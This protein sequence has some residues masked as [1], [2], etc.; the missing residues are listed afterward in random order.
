MLAGAG[1]QHLMSRTWPTEASASSGP[2]G[3]GDDIFFH[4]K[5]LPM[6][7]EPREGA[8]VDFEMGSDPNGATN[9]PDVLL[10]QVS[11]EF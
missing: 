9:V 11:G 7:T 1:H 8:R 10:P 4:V 5:S 3:G 6:G 2:D